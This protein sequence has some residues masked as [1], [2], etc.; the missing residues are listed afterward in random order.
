MTEITSY[1]AFFAGLVS[2]FSPCLL[3]MIP[4]YIMY[5]SGLG[6]IEGANDSK[7]IVLKRTLAFIAGFTIIFIIMGLSASF[8][9]QIFSQNRSLF[10]KLS[11]IIIIIFGLNY[12]GVLN[13]S[14]LSKDKR[15][16]A[17][18]KVNGMISSTFM[19]MAFAGGWSP[20]FGPVLGSILFMASMDS[21]VLKGG[22]L[23]FIYSIGMAV[24]FILTALFISKFTLLLS[25]YEKALKVIP[26]IGGGIL[27]VFGILIFFDKLVVLSS[28]LL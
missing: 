16:K 1:S 6:D 4:A 14:F 3:P 13:F 9:G 5:I 11:G 2:F 22:I 23:L 15:L 10:M 26:L 28:L 21:S 12:M 27:V 24:P 18:K 25:K 20:C 17:P 8:V 7:A 19:G